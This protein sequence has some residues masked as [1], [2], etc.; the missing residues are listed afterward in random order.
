MPASRYRK[1]VAGIISRLPPAVTQIRQRRPEAVFGSGGT[2]WNL[3]DAAAREYR[4]RPLATGDLFSSEEIRATVRRL[5]A[6]GLRARGKVP[7]INPDRADI[8]IGGAAI[9]EAILSALKIRSIA[10]NRGGLREGLIRNYLSGY[11][12]ARSPQN[13]RKKTQSV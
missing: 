8:I 7:G 9:L 4:G 13:R 11:F 10:V 6:L 12:I 1:L 5:C 2:I 3:A